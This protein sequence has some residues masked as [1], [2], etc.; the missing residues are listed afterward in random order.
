[1]FFELSEKQVSGSLPFDNDNNN[2]L[3][4]DYL[5]FSFSTNLDKSKGNYK[6]NKKNNAKRNG[7]NI[8]RKLDDNNNNNNNNN[9]LMRSFDQ[10][11]VLSLAAEPR[12]PVCGG[13]GERTLLATSGSNQVFIDPT[14]RFCCWNLRI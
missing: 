1:M 14:A 2:L 3:N 6:N 8:K 12:T 9:I 4:S 11:Q 5:S 7:I 10:K 13:G